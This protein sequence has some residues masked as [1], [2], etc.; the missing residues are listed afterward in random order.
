MWQEINAGRLFCHWWQDLYES[1]L[2]AMTTMI[3]LLLVI[4]GFAA[5]VR[6]ARH[7]RFAGHRHTFLPYEDLD[8]YRDRE[9]ERLVPQ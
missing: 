4:G 2:T 1:R 7:D 3:F 8:P 9:R 6:S 5:L